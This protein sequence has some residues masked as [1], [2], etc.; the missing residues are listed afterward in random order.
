MNCCRIHEED[1]KV[2]YKAITRKEV[3]NNKIVG[4]LTM[5]QMTKGN[6]GLLMVEE[7]VG[8]VL[9]LTLCVT[10]LGSQVT[11]VMHVLEK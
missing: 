4:S 5:L 3:G 6:R 2:H 9:L 11:K 7:L 10:D 8:E 1:N